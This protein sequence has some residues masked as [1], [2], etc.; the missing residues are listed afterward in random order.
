M[1]KVVTTPSTASRRYPGYVPTPPDPVP[2]DDPNRYSELPPNPSNADFAPGDDARLFETWNVSGAAQQY[3]AYSILA[4]V[5]TQLVRNFGTALLRP[6][7]LAG[8]LLFLLL[9]AWWTLYK[10]GVAA[11]SFVPWAFA[12]LTL[13]VLGTQA[14]A[15]LVSRVLVATL[16]AVVIATF[17]DALGVHALEWRMRRL[18]VPAELRERWMGWWA[19]RFDA[20]ALHAATDTDIAGAPR[21]AALEARLRTELVAYHRRRFLLAGLI[22]LAL[23]DS[24]LALATLPIVGL[25]LV[26]R[27]SDAPPARGLVFVLAKAAEG[28][29]RYAA[30]GDQVLGRWRSPAGSVDARSAFADVAIIFAAI[31]F[32]PMRPYVDLVTG[33]LH[34]SEPAF[35]QLSWALAIDPLLPLVILGSAALV[36]LGRI[37]WALE[38]LCPHPSTDWT[39]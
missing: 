7:L 24:T 2:R 18:R 20:A 30:D 4:F 16:A 39:P 17:L 21:L 26:M 27:G 35:W 10:T 33:A 31:A 15:S 13:I 37:L 12:I 25:A 38:N 19:Q 1:R 5:V 28:W 11:L 36:V 14:S 34:L 3:L 23:L 9:R 6:R 22:P 32:L 29:L 8:M